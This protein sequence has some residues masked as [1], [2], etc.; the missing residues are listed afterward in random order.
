[1]RNA[2]FGQDSDGLFSRLH[3]SLTASTAGLESENNAT[4]VYLDISA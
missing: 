4:G 3:S 2:L 1:V